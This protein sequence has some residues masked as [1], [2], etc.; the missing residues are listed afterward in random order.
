MVIIKQTLEGS[1]NTTDEITIKIMPETQLANGDFIEINVTAKAI[2]PYEKE[3]LATFKI[4]A[5]EEF[6]YITN[7]EESS[8]KEYATLYIETINKDENITIKYDTTKV[9]LDTN[10]PLINTANITQNGNINSIP[11]QLEKESIYNM[12]FIKK[13]ANSTVSLG[14]DIQVVE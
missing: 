2:E 8:N 13:D 10:N 9:T 4:Y 12:I 7:L 11:V 1:K 6:K 3:L 14:K 5:S